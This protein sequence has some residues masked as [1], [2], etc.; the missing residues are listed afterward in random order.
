MVQYKVKRE[1]KT[2]TI[3]LHSKEDVHSSSCGTPVCYKCKQ[4][5]SQLLTSNKHADTL[6]LKYHK[7][8]NSYT[9]Q[10]SFRYVAPHL[11]ETKTISSQKRETKIGFLKQN[12]CSIK[13]C[14][15]KGIRVVQT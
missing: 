10:D 3:Y 9:R 8:N 4:V 5:P 7:A 15:G 12:I 14:S 11:K 1:H 6:K 13:Y 2:D